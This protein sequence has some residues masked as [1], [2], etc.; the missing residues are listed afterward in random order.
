M[1]ALN[2]VNWHALRDIL[3]EPSSVLIGVG[4]ALIVLVFLIAFAGPKTRR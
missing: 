3:L 1:D 2:R 4:I